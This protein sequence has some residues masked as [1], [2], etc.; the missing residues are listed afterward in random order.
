MG[1]K[2]LVLAA[3][4]GVGYASS[5]Y[6]A[7]ITKTD[8]FRN[9]VTHGHDHRFE[10]YSIRAEKGDTL[11]S[12][13]HQFW[14]RRIGKMNSQGQPYALITAQDLL[15]GYNKT[16]KPESPALTGVAQKLPPGLA[17]TYTFPAKQGLVFH[18][19]M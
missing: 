7:E 17:F 9:T 11:E 1:L 12:I 15:E 14:L 10:T 13:A 19:Q 6:A 16:K 4:V 8:E 18:F 2:S 3:V 5:A